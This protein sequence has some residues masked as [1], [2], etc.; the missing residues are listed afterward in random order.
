MIIY[1]GANCECVHTRYILP[2]RK[3][4]CGRLRRAICNLCPL[5]NSCPI[6]VHLTL[7]A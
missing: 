6:T 7:V 4:H 3:C 5:C 2:V 1:G